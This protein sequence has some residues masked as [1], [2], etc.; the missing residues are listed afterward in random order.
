MIGCEEGRK[1]LAL[2]VD[3]SLSRPFKESEWG[4]YEDF[5]GGNETGPELSLSL[6]I[7]PNSQNPFVPYYA[8]RGCAVEAERISFITSTNS[9]DSCPGSPSPHRQSPL[10][11]NTEKRRRGRV[12]GLLAAFLTLALLLT[13]LL[14]STS[15]PPA[16]F[17][18]SP[19]AWLGRDQ[20]HTK[21]R[22][23]PQCVIIG[24]RK[25]G[26]RAL[27]DMLNLHPQVGRQQAT[28]PQFPINA[29]TVLLTCNIMHFQCTG[30]TSY[31]K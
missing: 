24:A 6:P 11:P 1:A 14:H 17:S 23:L 13:S 16:P 10:P 22:R 21:A 18:L 25:C 2:G 27:I 15:D 9:G 19:Q 8:S 29:C 12:W 20:S 3:P 28:L 31:H 4:P 30:N 5:L 7:R 26:T